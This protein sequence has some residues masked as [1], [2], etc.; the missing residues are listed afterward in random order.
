MSEPTPPTDLRSATDWAKV[1][2]ILDYSL[3]PAD[4]RLTDA[5]AQLVYRPATY[6]K[7]SWLPRFAQPDELITVGEFERRLGA[8]IRAAGA[9]P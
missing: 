1:F 2:L 4:G 9:A 6:W 8:A 5:G 3:L 7:E